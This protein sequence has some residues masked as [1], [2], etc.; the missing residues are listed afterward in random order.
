MAVL[1]CFLGSL[2]TIA[3]TIVALSVLF[4]AE[5]W[6]LG[7]LGAQHKTPHVIEWD[8]ANIT[9]HPDREVVP[10]PVALANNGKN[11][12][13]FGKVL[14]EVKADREHEFVFVI[15]RPTGFSTF[16]PFLQVFT[17]E[18]IDVGYEP[19]LGDQKIAVVIQ[20]AR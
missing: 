1:M 9:V 12:T 10:I 15:V 13:A 17:Q 16:L 2:V 7:L 3:V 5:V 14:A 11:D 20:E 8:G 18:K 4:P 19:A 6:E